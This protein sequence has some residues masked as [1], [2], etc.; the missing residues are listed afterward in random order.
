MKGEENGE[1]R[2]LNKV[3]KCDHSNLSDVW[4]VN[5]A[6]RT[7]VTISLLI[8]KLLPLFGNYALYVYADFESDEK[9]KRH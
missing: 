4:N 8:F 5:V 6:H 3:K 7:S 9:R 1:F 2:H